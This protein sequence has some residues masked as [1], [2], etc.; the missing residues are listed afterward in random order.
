MSAGCPSD[1][2]SNS[3]V[4]WS[5]VRWYWEWEWEWPGYTRSVDAELR[6]HGSLTPP[7][8]SP[9]PHTPSI[10]HKL[11]WSVVLWMWCQYQ[12]WFSVLGITWSASHCTAPAVWRITLLIIL[13]TDP[14]RCRVQGEVRNISFHILVLFFSIICNYLVFITV[15]VQGGEWRVFDGV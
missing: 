14:A 13:N 5:V 15:H 7:A 11:T 4:W 10:W 1:W 8:V 9:V 2:R 12:L 6:S 3:G